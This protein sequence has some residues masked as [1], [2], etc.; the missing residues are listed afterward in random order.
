[1]QNRTSCWRIDAGPGVGG[2][3]AAPA[4]VDR[5]VVP[6]DRIRGVGVARGV[7]IGGEGEEEA[8]EVGVDEVVVVVVRGISSPVSTIDLIT[9]MD[10]EGEMAVAEECEDLDR[11]AAVV[12]EEE[13]EA[14]GV[15]IVCRGVV[16]SVRQWLGEVEEGVQWE[17]EIEVRMA[18]EIEVQ[19]EGGE[20]VE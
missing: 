5:A 20:I 2:V 3:A 9:T 4:G 12:V 16:R 8:A 7:R 15:L 1:M 17:E 6:A 11:G 19:R 13:E 14:E 18:G 10:Q